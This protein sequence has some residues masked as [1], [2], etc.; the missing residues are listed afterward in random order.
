MSTELTVPKDEQLPAHLIE[1]AKRGSPT[2]M[3]G[4]DTFLTPPRLKIMQ[5]GREGEFKNFPEGAVIV[6]PTNEVVCGPK[7]FFAFTVL[8]RYEQFCVHN[9]F[10]RPDDMTL[11][12]EA[13]FDFDSE[14]ASKCLNFVSEPFPE[15]PTLQ[16]RYVTHYNSLIIVH[17]IPALARTPVLL[18]QFIGSAKSGRRLLDLLKVRTSDGT[19]IYV[20]NVMAKQTE[21]PGKK[22]YQGLEISNPTADVDCGRWVMDLAEV[23]AYEA[24]HEKCKAERDRFIV[25]YDDEPTAADAVTS[26]TLG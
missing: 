9:P 5:A 20:H 18:S 17:G 22:T 7:G 2:G 13:T 1:Y 12:R 6:T 25:T 15:N 19:P 11:I 21:L 23:A 26:D 10:D 3:E 24:L 8:Y 14:V 4:A 16:I